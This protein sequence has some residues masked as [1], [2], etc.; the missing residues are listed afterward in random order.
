MNTQAFESYESQVRSYC[1]N[2]PAV[3]TTAKGPFLYDE[4][5]REYIDFFCGAGGLNYGHNPDAIKKKVIEYLESDGVMHALDMYTAPKRDFIEFYEEKILKPR[6]LPYKL[7]FRAEIGPEGEETAER[8]CDD[9]GLPRH[10]AGV[11]CADHGRRQPGRCR[12]ALDPCNPYSGAVYVPGAGHG[13][14]YGDAAYGR[15]LGRG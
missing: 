7:Q 10:D 14:V 1:R 12:G 9:G 8:L 15:P 11:Y 4:D 13:T 2:F 5:G 6:G 3:F